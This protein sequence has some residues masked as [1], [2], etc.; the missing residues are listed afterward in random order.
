MHYS[1]HC[2]V[3]LNIFDNRPTL[4]YRHKTT[5]LLHDVLLLKVVLYHLQNAVVISNTCLLSIG[6]LCCKGC[7][8]HTEIN[9]SKLWTKDDEAVPRILG[10]MRGDEGGGVGRGEGGR[11][12][13]G[14]QS[15]GGWV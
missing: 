6:L 14:G 8:R 3:K 10:S 13:G 4:S 9:E 12:G 2:T 1:A 11:A 7:W 5:V 15:R